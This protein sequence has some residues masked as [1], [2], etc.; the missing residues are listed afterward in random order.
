MQFVLAAWVSGGFAVG[1]REIDVFLGRKG[2]L[3]APFLP[4][5]F[6]IREKKAMSAPNAI[7]V[8]LKHCA[9]ASEIKTYGT[10]QH[11]DHRA[12]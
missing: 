9:P 2:K 1:Q 12:R 5:P 11:R 10:S 4:P 3:S 6:R 8:L 7:G